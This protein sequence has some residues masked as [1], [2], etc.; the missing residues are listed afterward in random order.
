[1]TALAP[2]STALL[3]AM[4]MPRSLKTAG[5]VGALDLEIDVAAGERGDAV[6]RDERGAALQ[7]RDDGRRRG[8]RKPV[9]VLLDEATPC[10]GHDY[11]SRARTDRARPT[12]CGIEKRVYGQ[13]SRQRDALS[14]NWTS[15]MSCQEQQRR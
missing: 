1:M 7:Q 12:T 14:T 11:S 5:R 13:R 9:T 6:A 4:V 2:S 3:M 15:R 10:P 8:H